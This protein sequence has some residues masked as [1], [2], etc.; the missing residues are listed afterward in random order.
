MEDKIIE[1][2]SDN[3]RLSNKALRWKELET[4]N[5]A[6]DDSTPELKKK[7]LLD[8]SGVQNT[9]SP[10]STVS[11]IVCKEE[12][13]FLFHLF[14]NLQKEMLDRAAK[15]NNSESPYLKVSSSIVGLEALKRPFLKPSKTRSVL[16][17]SKF[18]PI[19]ANG[20]AGSSSLINNPNDNSKEGQYSIFKKP[21]LAGTNFAKLRQSNLAYNGFGG[22][23]KILLSEE[24]EEARRLKPF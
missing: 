14:L 10:L 17:A 21:R 2:E 23:S 16:T 18:S 7:R 6:N 24:K 13:R 9:P 19:K 5:F 22:S 15:I 12:G 11:I 8:Y 3:H 4:D 20:S 1:L